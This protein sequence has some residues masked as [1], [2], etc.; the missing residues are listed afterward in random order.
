MSRVLPTT[1]G[2]STLQVFAGQMQGAAELADSAPKVTFILQ[3]AGM[4]EDL[5]PEGWD[6]MA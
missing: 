5:S 1:A 3:H 2:R 4:I 6:R